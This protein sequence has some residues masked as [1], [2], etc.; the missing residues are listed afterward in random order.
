MKALI[1][2]FARLALR[3]WRIIAPLIAL[4]GFL[5]RL[6]ASTRRA[7]M[8]AERRKHQQATHDHILTRFRDRES[9]RFDADAA[10]Q[11]LRQRAERPD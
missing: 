6:S 9:V 1:A 3:H 5:W 4:L 7:G 11:W 10:R 8:R 2:P